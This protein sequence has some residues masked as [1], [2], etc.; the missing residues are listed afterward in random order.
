M[1]LVKD[2]L[3]LLKM[4]RNAV[5]KREQEEAATNKKVRE[6]LKPLL[7]MTEQKNLLAY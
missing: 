2:P 5:I 4:E 6:N 7:E 3:A 1:V